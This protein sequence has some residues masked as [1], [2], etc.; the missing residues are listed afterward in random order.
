M[1]ATASEAIRFNPHVPG[2]F[3]DPYAHYARLRAADPIH[4]SFMGSWVLTRYA[5]CEV[6]L[7]H[8]SFSSD[9][10]HW[11]GFALRYRDKELV[12]SLL[13]H[14]LLNTDPP[15]HTGLKRYLK[16][17]F[18]PTSLE[19]LKA[20]IVEIVED[21]LDRL[22]GRERF[23]LIPEYALAVPLETITHI[24]DIPRADMEQAKI[25]STEV[26]NLI[27]PLPDMGVLR[28]AD[29]A[30]IEF[31]AYLEARLGATGARQ[32]GFLDCLMSSPLRSLVDLDTYLLPNLVMLYAAGHETT[33]N[34]IGNGVYALLRHPD[35]MRRMAEDESLGESAVDELLRYDSSQQLAW[36]VAT[37]EVEVGGH[38]FHPGEQLMLL[39]GA[40][41]RDPAA[42]PAPDTLDLGRSPNRH[43]SFGR[44]RHN[45]MG[46]WLARLQGSIALRAFCRRFREASWDP[47][48]T[49][50]LNKLSF[51]GLR[52]LTIDVRPQT[53]R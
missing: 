33:V 46:A 44:G 10:R 41:N 48:A 45:C 35:Q 14:N 3:D 30:I 4:K 8:P 6:V 22:S 51:R 13:N 21:K 52:R 1:S 43:L 42:F 47:A 53:I 23:D 19:A 38:L 16:A 20:K 7:R 28:G 25:W 39:L 40:A 17:S 9:L 24:F 12:A 15:V 26:S 18:M 36:R 5:D 27:E 11:P 31:S 2:F 34:L 29:R 32:G 50:W 37:E 49:S